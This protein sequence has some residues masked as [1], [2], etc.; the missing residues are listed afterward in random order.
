MQDPE[1]SV[2]GPPN[3]YGHRAFSY[4]APTVWNRLPYKIRIA[5]SITLFRK[6]IENTIF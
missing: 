3:S 4:T 2:E 6:K 5:P 1:I